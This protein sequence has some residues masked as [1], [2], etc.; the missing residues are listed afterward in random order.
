MQFQNFIVIFVLLIACSNGSAV[1]DINSLAQRKG[2][3]IL[4]VLDELEKVASVHKPLVVYFHSPSDNN[5]Q[6]SSFEVI[7][8]SLSSETHMSQYTF[9]TMALDNSDAVLFDRFNI[10]KLPAVHFFPSTSGGT[11]GKRIEHNPGIDQIKQHL[12]KSSLLGKVIGTDEGHSL[13]RDTRKS[14]YLYK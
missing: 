12:E 11:H 6:D 1:V 5:K 2:S 4:K 9:A 3:T 10:R 13:L 8:H 7:I 14:S